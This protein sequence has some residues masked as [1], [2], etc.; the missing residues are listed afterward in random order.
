MEIN[1]DEYDQEFIILLAG[2]NNKYIKFILSSRNRNLYERY[3]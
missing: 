3:G 2:M 1:S